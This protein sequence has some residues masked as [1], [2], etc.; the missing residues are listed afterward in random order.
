MCLVRPNHSLWLDNKVCSSNKRVSHGALFWSNLCDYLISY[1]GDAWDKSSGG[2]DQLSRRSH[3]LRRFQ[4]CS[5]LKPACLLSVSTTHTIACCLS[6]SS[7]VCFRRGPSVVR[8]SLMI[9]LAENISHLISFFLSFSLTVF[10][11]LFSLCI[12][13]PLMATVPVNSLMA[14]AVFSLTEAERLAVW[15]SVKGSIWPNLLLRAVKSCFHRLLLIMHVFVWMP[16]WHL[17]CLLA[18][19][20]ISKQLLVH[21]EEV[22]LDPNPL[23][24]VPSWALFPRLFNCGLVW[25][26]LKLGGVHTWYVLIMFA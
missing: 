26:G 1:L 15:W 20:Y 12:F 11:C 2:N 4:D 10:L 6:P 16:M 8:P 3:R 13:E 21:K 24:S 23:I 22:D 7:C 9:H 5:V 17:P 19:L 25:A 18:C 14:F